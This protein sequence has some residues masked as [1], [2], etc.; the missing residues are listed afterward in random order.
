MLDMVVRYLK[1]SQNSFLILLHTS[2]LQQGYF[3][4]N[5]NNDLKYYKI[6][7]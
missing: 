7:I 3:L 5:L 2:A 6:R 1:F 4:K